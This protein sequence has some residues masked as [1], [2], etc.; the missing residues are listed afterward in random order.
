MADI[1]KYTY[2]VSDINYRY[3]EI[4]NEIFSL[5]V[6]KLAKEMFT[7][8]S[9]LLKKHEDDLKILHGRLADIQT[10]LDVLPQNELNIRRGKEILMAL[11]NYTE[12]LIKSIHYLQ[13][14]CNDK[15][16]LLFS[17]SNFVNDRK[18]YDYAMQHHKNLG[19]RLNTLLSSF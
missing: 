9:V 8:Q 7:D 18:A 19:V 13:M 4:H 16:N 11:S 3:Q 6:R 17:D 12:A 10:A 14:I 1:L 5:S 15:K 2:D